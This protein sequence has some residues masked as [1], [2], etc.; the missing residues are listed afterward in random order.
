VLLACETPM[1]A[2]AI[3]DVAVAPGLTMEAAAGLT[4][5]AVETARRIGRRRCALMLNRR[6]DGMTALRP[7]ALMRLAA[8]MAAAVIV[9]VLSGR[10]GRCGESQCCG[11]DQSSFH[12]RLFDEGWS[13]V[14][15]SLI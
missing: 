1:L 15:E 3:L 11:E 4:G 13:L 6:P 7:P 12:I 8:G 14:I 10:G 5:L 9:M 2:A